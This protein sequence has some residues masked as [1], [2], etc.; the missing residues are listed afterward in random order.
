[1]SHNEPRFFG[2]GWISGVAGLALGTLGLAAVL[3]FRFPSLLTVPEL[4]AL[5]PVPYV[6][7]LLH[8]VL[9][10]AFVLGAMSACLRRRK[11]LGMGAIVLTLA[12]AL[13]GGS[14]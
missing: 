4:R 7:A 10:G 11:V 5:Y 9:V 12:A 8:L 6:R 3:C 14:S 1:M 13:L 2:S